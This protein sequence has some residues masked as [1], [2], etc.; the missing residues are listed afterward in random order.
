[1]LMR[2][3]ILISL[4]C[5]CFYSNAQATKQYTFTHYSTANGL[6][7][8]HGSFI[9]QDERGFIW[10]S[11]I[12]GLQRF[13]GN[14]FLTFRSDPFNKRSIPSDHIP[15]LY[16]DKRKRMWIIGSNNKV[17][18]FNTKDFTFQETPVV[19]Q[20]TYQN[21]RYKYFVETPDAKLLLYEIRGDIFRYDE[22]KRQFLPDF[23]TLPLPKGWRPA[24]ITW[25]SLNKK[26]WVTTDSGLVL[27]NPANKLL[28]Y[29]GHNAEQDPVIKHYESLNLVHAI[30]ID[31]KRNIS[32]FQWLPQQSLPLIHY[33][34]RTTGQATVQNL[35][36]ALQLGYH[37]LYGFLL[38][39][40]SRVWIY[41]MPL[42][43]EWSPDRKT[44]VS[45]IAAANSGGNHVSFQTVS[46]TLEDRNGNIWL[47]TDNGVILF[48]PDAQLFN[49][50][51]LVPINKQEII[52]ATIRSLKQT[53]EGN[54]ITSTVEAGLFY[55]DKAW[56]PLPLPSQMKAIQ[57]QATIW[58]MH[59]HTKTGKFW[60]TL[61]RGEKAIAVFDAL[62][63][64]LEW[65]TDSVFN[66][67][68][69]RQVEEDKEGNLWFGLQ[70]GRVI[71][72]QFNPTTN[73]KGYS[74]ILDAY[75]HITKIYTDPKGYLW[76]GTAGSGLIKI[77]PKNNK[78]IKHF[79][80]STTED[81]QLLG[82]NITDIIAYNDTTLIAVAGHLELVNLN[83]HKVTHLTAKEGLPSNTAVSIQKDKNGILWLGMK[84][85]LCR[86]NLAHK[87][88]TLYD[89]KDGL[90]YDNFSYPG[91][92]QLLNDQL[93]F[94]TSKNAVVI[95]SS[96]ISSTPPSAPLIT[97]FWSGSQL[98]QMDSLFQASRAVFSHN[99]SNITI[100]FSNLTYVKQHK[101]R[102]Y[103][104]LK[105][106]DKEWKKADESNL[107]IYNYIPPGSYTFLVKSQNED[108]IFSTSTT[109]FDIQIK[110]PFWK[111]GL[112]YALLALLLFGLLFIIDNERIKR[113]KT[114]HKIRAQIAVDLHKDISA[115][116]TDINLLSEMAKIKADKNPALSKDIIQR[117]STQSRNMKESMNEMLWSIDPN[118][119]SMEKLLL[120]MKEF[121]DG[122]IL[123]YHVDVE[124]HANQKVKQLPL[125]MR[126]R[127]ELLQFYKDAL[128]YTTQP[129]TCTSILV[130]MDY[131]KEQISLTLLATC[132]PKEE[133]AQHRTPFIN[134]MEKR[135]D[136]LNATLDINTRPE[137]IEIRLQF[138]IA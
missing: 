71:K 19:Y 96:F 113:V 129:F 16:L 3:I 110:P 4:L 2:W 94:S 52:D 125:N 26:Y 6:A 34:N 112:F 116:L 9:R 65:I 121:T 53:K 43:I 56:N 59:Q 55:F 62:T 105:G 17:G 133:D 1:M 84:T 107:A 50:Y 63:N 104:M 134:N 81:N 32:F 15:V 22:A 106:L 12:N 111:T 132:T 88:Y 60:F 122:F 126:S 36:D 40:N 30:R 77:D 74:L 124:F 66:K 98:L 136:A 73:E 130:S 108:G 24:N 128:H 79:T 138:S 119:D 85:G 7:A 90:P 75:N 13:D 69:V 45:A 58:D 100:A 115:A 64:R 137:G 31:F 37:E 11:T 93:L 23:T 87:A 35:K 5:A 117:I 92:F 47:A 83:N 10:I 44:F 135:A 41:G 51:T 29:R 48:N 89:R 49:T 120:R 76:I 38:Q 61:Q 99:N 82:N 127:H 28:S 67:R 46:A 25:D 27:Y 21:Y 131:I 18:L 39:R 118:N 109:A 72:W 20:Q 123:I 78:V 14:R 91:A 80:T 101:V 114:I 70:G 97:S 54:I 42:F 102:Y 68:T 57:E 86:V 8:N 95:N 33:Y 103:Y